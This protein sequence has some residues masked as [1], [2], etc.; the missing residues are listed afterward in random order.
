MPYKQI[1]DLPQQVKLLPIS[2]KKIFLKAF[3]SSIKNNSEERS[4]KNAWAA[5]KKFFVKK[6]N[7]WVKKT[8]VKV[9][10]VLGRSGVFGKQY[11]FDAA[12][13]STDLADDGLTVSESLLKDLSEQGRIDKY[14]DVDHLGLKGNHSTNNLFTMTNQRYK[15]GKLY[16]RFMIDKSHD[17]YKWFVSNYYKENIELSAEFI[18]Y[19]VSGNEITDCKRLGWTVLLNE[20]P[21]DKNA[22][23]F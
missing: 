18:D 10:S 2:A 17:Q 22:V 8:S 3:N 21:A 5:V 15:D 16:G 19:Q 7:V 14:G 11:Y 12:I 9:K 4:F 6:N 20:T 13:S 23:A 1:S